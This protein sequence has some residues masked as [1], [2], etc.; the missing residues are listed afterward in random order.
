M[1]CLFVFG[2]F[3]FTFKD[4]DS[5]CN[6]GWPG[7]NMYPT[8]FLI[9]WSSYFS[10]E[11]TEIKMYTPTHSCYFITFNRQGMQ[12]SLKQDILILSKKDKKWKNEGRKEG[13]E[14][15]KELWCEDLGYEMIIAKIERNVLYWQSSMIFMHIVSFYAHNTPW[16]SGWL[17]CVCS[18]TPLIA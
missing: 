14:E 13:R 9:F 5:R 15:G 10:L 12:E 11:S 18:L 7:I 8:L 1:N 6:L 4:N 2:L 16:K 3:I 17:W